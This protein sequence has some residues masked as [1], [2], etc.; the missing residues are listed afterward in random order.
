MRLVS[1]PTVTS[2][3]TWVNIDHLL[4]IAQVEDENGEPVD[5]QALLVLS[6]GGESA[7]VRTAMN[8]DEAAA[9]IAAVIESD[10][11]DE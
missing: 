9:V 3:D 8:A 5:G 4:Y 11:G 2:L 7:W 6:S 1:F 10:D